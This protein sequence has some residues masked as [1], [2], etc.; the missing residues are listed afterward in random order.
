MEDDSSKDA[1]PM[2]EPPVMPQVQGSPYAVPE[3]HSLAKEREMVAVGAVALT[4]NDRTMG[5]LVHLLG[6]LTGFIGVLILWLIKKD[7]SKFVDFH[8]RE[9]LNF[10]ISMLIYSVVLIVPGVIIA[11]MTMGV[12]M[13][14]LIPLLLL[15]GV[16]QLVCEIM[17]C[18]AANRGEWHRYPFT[19][20]L[21]RDAG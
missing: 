9:A 2:N 13:L 16:A 5:M 20:R 4:E 11:I 6:L 7:Q 3:S 15:L 18:I 17:A 14:L 19:I 8:G 21:I 12:G 1:Q 10:M